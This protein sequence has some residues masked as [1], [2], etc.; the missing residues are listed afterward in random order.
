MSGGSFFLGGL[1]KDTRRC[2]LRCLQV[3]SSSSLLFNIEF[4]SA[5]RIA[6]FS[7]RHRSHARP[8]L[9]NAWPLALIDQLTYQ[10]D[11][12]S[13]NFQMYEDN[14]VLLYFMFLKDVLC[15]LH[16]FLNS[17]SVNPQVRNSKSHLTLSYIVTSEDS[18]TAL[19]CIQAWLYEMQACEIFA[20]LAKQ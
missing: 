10:G 2:F 8:P 5:I 3:S 7:L 14:V 1:N 6:S 11:S 4:W 15:T 17:L 16:L 13:F 9:E 20:Y 12:L 18:C 19:H